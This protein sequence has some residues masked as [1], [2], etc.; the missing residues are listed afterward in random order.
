M[1]EHGV[2]QLLQGLVVNLK[3]CSLF[4][5]LVVHRGELQATA[6]NE[7]GGGGT[8]NQRLSSSGQIVNRKDRVLCLCLC[9][10]SEDRIKGGIQYVA[11][12]GDLQADRSS[13]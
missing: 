6:N 13:G 8:G 9:V 7:P 4:I 11:A 10:D 3:C 5:F 2:Q 12:G 1:N